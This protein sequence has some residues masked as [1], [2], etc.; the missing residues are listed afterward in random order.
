MMIKLKLPRTI[1]LNKADELIPIAVP[2]DD[3]LLAKLLQSTKR[4]STTAS[5]PGQGPQ[6]LKIIRKGGA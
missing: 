6:N 4:K 5:K 3:G 2:T 1:N